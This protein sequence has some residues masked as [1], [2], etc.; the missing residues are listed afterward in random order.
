MMRD[1]E[2]KPM[3]EKPDRLPRGVAPL[4]LK[5]SDAIILAHKVNEMASGSATYDTFSQIC[6]NTKTSSSFQRKV[7]ALRSFGIIEDRDNVVALSELGNRITTPRDERDDAIATKEAMLRIDLLGKMFERHRGRLLPEDQF[8]NNILIQEF[9]VPREVS[10]MW[11]EHFRDALASAKLIFVR[12]DAK[13]QVLDEPSGD[14]RNV[15]RNT[16]QPENVPPMAGQPS[17]AVLGTISGDAIPIPLGRGRTAHLH[18]PAD[19]DAKRDLDRMLKMLRI[20]LAEE[21]ISEIEL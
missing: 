5:L 16:P 20:S 3:S 13:T 12:P 15:D 17:A 21:E 18:L 1:S 9:K 6:G 2:I 8:L 14:M 19:W 7:A 4:A 11:V 10:R